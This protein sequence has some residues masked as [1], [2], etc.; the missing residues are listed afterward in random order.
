MRRVIV[1]GNLPKTRGEVERREVHRSSQ[2]IQCGIDAWKRVDILDS[3][4]VESSVVNT[5]ACGAILLRYQHH[6]CCPRTLRRPDYSL[7]KHLINN[8]LD[9][10]LFRSRHA[11]ASTTDRLGVTSVNLVFNLACATCVVPKKVLVLHKQCQ[12]LGLLLWCKVCATVS[13]VGSNGFFAYWY[14]HR[15]VGLLLKIS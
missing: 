3:D 7:L 1:H 14:R 9:L 5:E 2:A 8:L 4:A 10:G 13:D 15:Q 6:R 12:D 11:V